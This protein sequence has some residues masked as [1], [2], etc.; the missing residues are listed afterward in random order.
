MQR[1]GVVLSSRL[2]PRVL[3]AP[4]YFFHAAG[5]VALREAGY[6][7][8]EVEGVVRLVRLTELDHPDAK[9]VRV[10]TFVGIPFTR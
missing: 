8:V 3:P 5:R 2:I 9:H 6:D 4:R 10:G 7:D 1:G